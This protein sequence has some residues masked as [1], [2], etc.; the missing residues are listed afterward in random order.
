MPIGS[1]KCRLAS[2]A[3]AQSPSRKCFTSIR[4]LSKS[5]SQVYNL[6]SNVQ[7]GFFR[8]AGGQYHHQDMSD[9]IQIK[10]VVI[11]RFERPFEW[12]EDHRRQGL[13]VT[14][15]QLFS[16]H[17]CRRWLF[18]SLVVTLLFRLRICYS[19]ENLEWI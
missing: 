10:L 1:S 5:S 11:I 18:I 17:C 13:R 3:H 19:N 9:K 2:S 12:W 16:D 15:R 4:P 6:H 7:V 8:K 14:R